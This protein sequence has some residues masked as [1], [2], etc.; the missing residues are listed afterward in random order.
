MRLKNNVNYNRYYWRVVLDTEKS[1]TNYIE[2]TKGCYY[3]GEDY[4]CLKCMTPI[5]WIIWQGKNK[6]KSICSCNQTATLEI[7]PFNQEAYI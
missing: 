3:N 4:I 2:R 6:S 1:D 5:N 7:I